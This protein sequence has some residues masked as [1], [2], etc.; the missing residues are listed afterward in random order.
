MRTEVQVSY[1]DA[2]AHV[3]LVPPEGKPPTLDP[4]VIDA[5][6]AVCAG[7]ESRAETLVCAVVR[8]QSPRFFCAG[9]N[10]NVMETITAETVAAWVHRGHRLMNRLEAL[11]VPVVAVVEGFALGG[12]LELAKIG[13]ASCRERV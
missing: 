12:G 6:D 8:S 11:P 10:L 1:R 2:V 4:G 9:A 7:I 3:T 5:L 13:R